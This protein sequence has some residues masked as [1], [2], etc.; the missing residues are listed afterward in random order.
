M[1][2]VLRLLAAREHGLDPPWLLPRLYGG[3]MFAQLELSRVKDCARLHHRPV[4][5]LDVECQAGRYLLSGSGDNDGAIGIYDLL[6]PVGAAT[7]TCPVIASSH[8]HGHTHGISTVQWYPHD[9]GMFTS[10]S[11]DRSLSVWDTNQLCVVERF[12]FTEAVYTHSMASSGTHCL[13]AAGGGECKITLCDINSGSQT[14]ILR[15]HRKPVMALKWCPSRDHILTSGSQDNKILFWDIR[16]GS[17]PLFD[18]DQHNGGGMAQSTSAL[19]AHNGHVVGLCF[20]SDGLFLLSVA[21]DNHLRLWD[22]CT[23]KNSLIN[24]GRVP[25][26]LVQQ[27]CQLS[28]TSSLCSLTP[29]LAVP[30]GNDV[31][32]FELFTG[33]KV[34]ILKGHYGKV[35]SCILH[36]FEQELYSGGSDRN[37]LC[38]T[39]PP[40]TTCESQ[41]QDSSRIAAVYS[42]TWSDED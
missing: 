4:T 23:L 9:T 5:A 12:K 29:T 38:W 21:T 18:L 3:R 7:F 10:S 22:T 16:K 13:T 24:Y 14:H 25:I 34:A 6:R 27:T 11:L 35:T 32:L 15:G 2:D 39:P 31:S 42:D 19:S 28:I 8:N 41:T 30:T 20:T 40:H 1:A 37:I 36:P 26:S 33:K 17:G